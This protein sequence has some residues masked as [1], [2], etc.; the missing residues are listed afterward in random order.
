M[1]SI[2]KE[3]ILKNIRPLKQYIFNIHNRTGIT[4]IFQL[5]VGL[6]P[7]KSRK[8]NHKFIDTPVDTCLCSLNAETTRH[9]LLECPANRQEFLETIDYI[10]IL[11]D[12]E[13]ISDTQGASDTLWS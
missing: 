5:R 7:L 10:L 13:N 2:F 1:K 3:A 4:W 8:M 12:L 11:N 6:S 9:F